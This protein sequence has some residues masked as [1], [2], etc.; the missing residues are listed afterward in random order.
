M[1]LVK[2]VDSIVHLAAIVSPYVSIYTPE[3]TNEINI[4]GT[5]NILRAAVK[6]NLRRVVYAS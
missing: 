1:S 3:V 5:L 6:T 4:T 2:K